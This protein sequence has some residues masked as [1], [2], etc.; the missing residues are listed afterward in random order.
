M[1]FWYSV[2]YLGG[3]GGGGGVNLSPQQTEVCH[4][5]QK[6]STQRFGNL[7]K[8]NTQKSGNLKREAF[9]SVRTFTTQERK[10]LISS[11]HLSLFILSKVMDLSILP[12][13]R[14]ERN[15]VSLVSS[16]TKIA[17][18]KKMTTPRLELLAALVLSRGTVSIVRI[19]RTFY[20][21][22]SKTVLFW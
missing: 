14:A 13:V 6:S 12:R 16:K 21:S 19:S 5:D 9:F 2:L 15:Q 4:F 18:L 8:I 7:S 22:D 17:P 20:F 11:P 3:G 10:S 1:P